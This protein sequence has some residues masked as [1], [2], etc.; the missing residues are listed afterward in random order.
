MSLSLL[1]SCKTSFQDPFIRRL[2]ETLTSLPLVWF[3]Q[4]SRV[5]VDPFN[6]RLRVNH[7][8]PHFLWVFNPSELCLLMFMVA[9]YH[10]AKPGRVRGD[11]LLPCLRPAPPSKLQ[12]AKLPG[13]WACQ[14]CSIRPLGFYC[15]SSRVYG[16]TVN[17]HFFKHIV[18]WIPLFIYKYAKILCT[19]NWE[20][21]LHFW[22]LKVFTIYIG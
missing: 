4:D 7:Q 8:A 21:F 19:K 13:M 10:S 1:L 20:R 14:K 2:P 16:R 22:V 15:F 17:C 18:V 9:L 3:Q 5:H 12:P 11:P 6:H